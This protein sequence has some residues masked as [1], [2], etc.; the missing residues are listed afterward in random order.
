MTD[1][2]ILTISVGGSRSALS[3]AATEI[4]WPDLVER[5]RM[6]IRGKESHAAY[7]RMSKAQQDSL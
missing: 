6:P 1:G 2:R 3:W 4:S 7:M 5:L